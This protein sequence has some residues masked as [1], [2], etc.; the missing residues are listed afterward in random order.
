MRIQFD[1]FADE[2]SFTIIE[3]ASNE[4]ILTGPDYDPAPF[5]LWQTTVEDLEFGDYKIIISDAGGDGLMSD[6]ENFVGSIEL[7]LDDILIARV[8]GNFESSASLPF[9]VESL[10]PANPPDVVEIGPVTTENDFVSVQVQYDG[11][12]DETSWSIYKDG[13]NVYDGPDDYDPLSFQ[14]WSTKF[15]IFPP[16]KYTFKVKDTGG[17]GLVTGTYKGFIRIS[18]SIDGVLTQLYKKRGG[19]KSGTSFDFN[20]T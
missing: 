18:Q 8:F 2:L 12:P 19:F 1:G 3:T 4:T 6:G 10:D 17:D 14:R 20:V 5:E 11:F 15:D 7:F 16:G 13:E 9:T